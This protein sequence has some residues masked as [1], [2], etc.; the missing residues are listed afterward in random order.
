MFIHLKRHQKCFFI[1]V[2]NINLITANRKTAEAQALR[3]S[4]RADP[5]LHL[6]I[7]GKISSS[8]SS[9][10]LFHLEALLHLQL[11]TFSFRYGSLPLNLFQSIPSVFLFVCQGDA[12]ISNIV[13]SRLLTIIAFMSTNNEKCTSLQKQTSYIVMLYK[14]HF[15]CIKYV[16]I[17]C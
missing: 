12:Q 6:P 7:T 13:Q 10:C 16:L 8:S 3:L 14:D 1:V 15:Q 11:T 4:L 9:Y 17:P 2:A 5:T